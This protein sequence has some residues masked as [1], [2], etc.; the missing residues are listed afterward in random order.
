MLFWTGCFVF[1][2]LLATP[3][4]WKWANKRKKK[5]WI[6]FW[7]LG[8]AGLALIFGFWIG[9]LSL[10]DHNISALVSKLIPIYLI[11]LITDAF[12][13]S[14][15][16]EKNKKEKETK[17]ETKKEEKN[18]IWFGIGVLLALTWI[19]M[20][21]IF[22]LTIK[23]DLYNLVHVQ[24]NQSKMQ[25]MD[26]KHIPTVPIE[27]AFYKAEKLIGGIPNS[28]YYKLGDLTRQKINGEEYWVAP[29]EFKGFFQS[30]KAKTTPGY[31]KVS[32]ERQDDEG[33]LVDSYHMKYVPSAYFG[34]SMARKIREKYP[35]DILFGEGF[36]PNDQGTPYYV[37]AVGH[38]AKYR[39]GEVVDGAVLVNPQTGEMQKYTIKNMPS[40]VD[41]VIPSSVASNYNEYQAKY[42]HGFWN[43]L[44]GKQ[45]ISD[46]TQWSSGEE[47][48]GVYGADGHM[49]WFTDHTNPGST[50]MVGYTLMD[51][52]TGQFTYYTG[53]KGFADGKASLNAV[54]NTFKKDQWTGTN[55]ILY[56]IY[57]TETWYIPVIDSNG[58]L[59]KIA[60]VN[61]QNPQ[62][63]AYGDTKQ[64]ALDGYKLLL[65]TANNQNNAIPTDKSDLKEITGKVLRV[66][67]TTMNGE[68]VIQVLLENSD[69]VFNINPQ[70]A[71][72]ASFIK[73]GD[74]LKMSYSD[75]GETM[76]STETVYNETLKR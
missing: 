60:M 74:V 44:F 8:K 31:I 5:K 11:I 27:S 36:E 40:F 71:V 76:I 39:S 22:P 25:V 75:T 2:F 1:F 35:H 65:A 9:Y 6:G 15:F 50:S 45:D 16:R 55:P 30:L 13:W 18:S 19:F 24:T 57:G 54:H 4:F 49:Y 53:S 28:S 42:K 29:I 7:Q 64:E 3:T 23:K 17:K 52:R 34:N 37:V 12:L 38:Y 70:Q 72:Y 32:A 67:T 48:L 14:S 66:S 10:A 51:G 43:T 56:N 20:T 58:L 41:Y 73:E 21:C 47:V 26:I 63:V 61:A 62:I 33:T 46:V 59:R 68:N 69:K